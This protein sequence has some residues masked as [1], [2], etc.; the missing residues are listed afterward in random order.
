MEKIIISIV[1]LLGVGAIAL[2]LVPNVFSKMG[3]DISD[4]KKYAE[5]MNTN[6]LDKPE[7]AQYKAQILE[8]GANATGM[9]GKFTTAV[10]T[11][12]NAA[13]KAGCSK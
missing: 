1:A 12:K 11:A 8:L 13:N 5:R 4:T 10:I 7:C 9:N 2:F 6:I 3:K